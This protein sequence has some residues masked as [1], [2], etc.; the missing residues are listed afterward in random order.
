MTTLEDKN[1]KTIVLSEKQIEKEELDGED[2]FKDVVE[3][4]IEKRFGAYKYEEVMSG[5]DVDEK[6]YVV[7]VKI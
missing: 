5:W 4:I 3:E 6:H 1:Y 7:I 2:D